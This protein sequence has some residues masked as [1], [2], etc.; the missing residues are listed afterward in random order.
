MDIKKQFAE[1]GIN[2]IAAVAAFFGAIIYLTVSEKEFRFRESIGQV[3]S[4]LAFAGWGTEFVVKWLRQ[5][6]SPSV[7]GLLGLAIG[8]CG[9]FAAKGVIKLGKRFE[10]D[11]AAFLTKKGKN[12]VADN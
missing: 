11:P 7:C 8:I 2:A 4:A 10:A 5:E 6:S 3:I 12:D 9:L 1:W